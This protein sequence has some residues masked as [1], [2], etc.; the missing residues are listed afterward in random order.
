MFG[1]LFS[2]ER[3][4]K[5]LFSLLASKEIKILTTEDYNLY[6]SADEGERRQKAKK[7][8][9]RKNP[10]WSRRVSIPKACDASC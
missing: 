4:M 10:L 3:G 8:R 7:R 9:V 2:R 1:R 5:V 6:W